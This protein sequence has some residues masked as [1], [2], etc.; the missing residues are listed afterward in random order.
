MNLLDL[1]T[2]ERKN[3]SL[4]MMFG[5]AVTF[6]IFAAIGLWLVSANLTYVFYLAVLAHVQIITIMTGFI[7]QLVKRRITAGKDGITIS[8]SGTEPAQGNNNV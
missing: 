1:E 4:W 8:D 3:L 5:G 7:A 6:T 2:N